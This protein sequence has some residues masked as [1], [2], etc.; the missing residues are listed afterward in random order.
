MAACEELQ[1][2][3]RK[4]I[5]QAVIGKLNELKEEQSKVLQDKGKTCGNSNNNG[6]PEKPS[7]G[8]KDESGV[9]LLLLHLQSAGHNRVTLT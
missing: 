1:E 4:S 9:K 8:D 5:E 3:Y 6:I 7:P 2:T